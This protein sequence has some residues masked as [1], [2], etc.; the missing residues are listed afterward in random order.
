[1]LVSDMRLTGSLGDAVANDENSAAVDLT[2]ITDS[3]LELF[4]AENQIL[5]LLESAIS[6]EI[7]K[8]MKTGKLPPLLSPPFPTPPHIVL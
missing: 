1:M 5:R 8:Q 7:M 4:A 3:L 2:I 6:R